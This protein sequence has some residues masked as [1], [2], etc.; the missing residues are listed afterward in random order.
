MDVPNAQTGGHSEEK[1][2]L[3]PGTIAGTESCPAPADFSDNGESNWEL[4]LPP[5]A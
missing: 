2:D 4:V 5:A 1:W 3:W